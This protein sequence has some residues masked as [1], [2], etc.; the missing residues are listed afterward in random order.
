MHPS[1][2][3]VPP[4]ATGAPL[5]AA[6][7]G[8]CHLR[9]ELQR[10]AVVAIALAGGLR[11][12]VEHVTLVA[13]ATR[14]VVFGAWQHELEIGLGAQRAVDRR[15]KA[16]PSRATLVLA[17]RQEQRQIATGAHEGA[18]AL[19]AVQWAGAGALG[20]FLAQHRILRRA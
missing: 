3:A 14:A 9:H 10:D 2:C 8:S 15:V 17:L 12:V 19:F 20:A 6:G 7:R 1:R 18:L 16:R 5:R 13:V 11:A 4:Y